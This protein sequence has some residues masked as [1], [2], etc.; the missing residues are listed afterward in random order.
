MLKIIMKLEF[1]SIR[2]IWKDLFLKELKLKLKLSTR[3]LSKKT[4]CMFLKKMREYMNNYSKK[5][6]GKL[7]F[8]T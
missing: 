3:I 2:K 7:I 1:I 6:I 4:L 5:K 8:N